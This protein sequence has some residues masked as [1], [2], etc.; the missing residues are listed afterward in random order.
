VAGLTKDAI[1]HRLEAGR[2]HRLHRGV[3]AVGHV[4]LTQRARELAAVLAAGPN[5][6]LSHRSAGALWGLL[7]S[8]PEIEV[9]TERSRET[10]SGFTV[11]RSRR[12]DPQDRSERDGVPVTS[13]ARTLVDLAD[14]L[15]E[16]RI[17]DAFHEA[18]VQR[19]FDLQAVHETIE[20]LPGRRGRHKL[21]RTLSAYDGLN[22]HT[23]SEAERRFL[24]ICEEHDLP[25]P[26]A[27]ASIHGY[28]VDFVWRAQRLAVE[29]DGKAVHHTARAFQQDRQRDRA[30]A[31]L[32]IQV[33][34]VTWRDLDAAA[35]LARQLQVILA[36]R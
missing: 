5:A 24:K 4:A 25:K 3:Y 17:A 10:R 6:L 2:L 15:S 35:A 7:R 19:L 1:Y 33:V 12:I 18:E 11:H 30:L 23:R 32:G 27:N 22:P 34:R 20:R 29:V 36:R 13:V 8:A 26:E 28:E 9:T 16:R 21:R 31:A 14:V